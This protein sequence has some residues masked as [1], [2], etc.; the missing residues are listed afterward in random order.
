[1]HLVHIECKA[2]EQARKE[3]ESQRERRYQDITMM[4]MIVMTG[5][6]SPTPSIL[7]TPPSN[8]ITPTKKVTEEDKLEKDIAKDM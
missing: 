6:K 2:T 3:C 8:L 4:M 7:S 1:M 5:S